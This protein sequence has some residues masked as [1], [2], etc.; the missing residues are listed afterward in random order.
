[1][2]RPSAKNHLIETAMRVF[3]QE[4]FHATGI[5]R[6]L[7]AANLSKMTLYRH[8]KSKDE[9]ILATIEERDRRFNAWMTEYV[10][11]ASRDPQERLLAVFDGLEEWFQGRAFPDDGFSGCMFINAA[12]EYADPHSPIHRAAQRH[13]DAI[14]DHLTDLARAAGVAWPRELASQLALLVE[15][16]TVTA[17]V[18]RDSGAAKN[19]KGIAEKL[20]AG[21]LN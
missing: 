18:R 3:Y 2:P 9:L 21:A 6:V 4:G 17:Q 14:V 20:V 15:G 8:F 19:A 11:A 5:E 16:A 12:A 1:M 13:K 7:E 10:E